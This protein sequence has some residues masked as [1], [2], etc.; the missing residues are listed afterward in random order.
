MKLT[1]EENARR[2]AK[3]RLRSRDRAWMEARAE[4]ARIWRASREW[5]NAIGQYVRPREAA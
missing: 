3:Y 5:Q 4:R 2:R 1:E